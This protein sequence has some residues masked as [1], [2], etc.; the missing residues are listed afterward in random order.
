MCGESVLSRIHRDVQ[1]T[2]FVKALWRLRTSAQMYMQALL[3][4]GKLRWLVATDVSL[5]A[6]PE[7]ECILHLLAH[8]SMRNLSLSHLQSGLDCFVYSMM[9]TVLPTEITEQLCTKRLLVATPGIMFISL[10]SI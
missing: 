2:S 6:C 4:S 5:Y 1:L 8:Q 7:S 3:R 9:F 10:T